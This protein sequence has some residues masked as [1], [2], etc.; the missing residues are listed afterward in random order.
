MR[1]LI[2]IGFMGA[3]KTSVG[4]YLARDA[5]MTFVDTDEQIVAEQ[6]M[7]I[8]AIFEKYGEP[9]FRDLE[10]GLLERMQT[11]T[12]DSVISVGGG[13]PVREQNREL[14]RSLGCVIYLQATKATI[15][16]RVQNDGTRPMLRGEDM[17]ARVE[18][19]MREREALYREAAHFVIHTD[20]QDIPE[21]ARTVLSEARKFGY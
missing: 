3:G 12:E 2:L 10:T 5:G 11:D 9:Y 8:S 1:N 18:R 15:L 14:L 21:V 16:G 13:M 20:G 7:E 6:G 19:L 17:E 4:K